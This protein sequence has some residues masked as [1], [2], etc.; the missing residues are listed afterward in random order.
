MRTTTLV[1]ALL[2]TLVSAGELLPGQEK[3]E[4]PK[5][6]FEECQKL[7]DSLEGLDAEIREIEHQLERT[8]KATTNY[9]YVKAQ[10]AAV[11][12]RLEQWVESD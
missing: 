6:I 2:L 9:E 1:A 11:I 10:N 4:S 3:S 7:Q 12:E 8:R 5:A